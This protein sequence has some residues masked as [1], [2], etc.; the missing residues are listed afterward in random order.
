[1]TSPMSEELLR[2]V[3]ESLNRHGVRYVVFGGIAV[4]AHGLSRATKDLDLF[5]DPTPDNVDATRLALLEVFADQALEE[6][7]AA[8]LEEYGLIRYGLPEH[9]F[10][11]DLTTRIGEMFRYA[12]LE[13]QRVELLGVSVSVAT[14]RQLVRMKRSTGR[15]QD[16]ADVL[17]LSEQFGLE[18]E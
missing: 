10:V 6:I 11:I 18:D 1:M 16:Q 17:R 4:G 5:L 15:P 2:A 12:D 13:S 3:F 14:P 7:T 9:D 8:E